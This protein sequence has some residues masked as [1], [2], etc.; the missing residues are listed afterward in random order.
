M[1]SVICCFKK[2]SSILGI[3]RVINMLKLS[4]V[5]TYE[6]LKIKLNKMT[7]KLTVFLG[8]HLKIVLVYTVGTVR[9]TFVRKLFYLNR[10]QELPKL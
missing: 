8:Y 1:I 6:R 5:S 2:Y 9:F 3:E 4:T 7:F 10:T